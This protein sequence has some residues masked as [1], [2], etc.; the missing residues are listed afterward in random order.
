VLVSAGFASGF[1]N[2]IIGAVMFERI[3]PALIGRV[4]ALVNALCWVLLPF[5][6]VVGGVLIAALGLPTAFAVMGIIYL[7]ATMLPLAL[8]GFRQME[9][10]HALVA[11]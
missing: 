5:G 9:R 7:A 2:P 10:R 1:L 3:P 8:P 4:T 6:G 11:G